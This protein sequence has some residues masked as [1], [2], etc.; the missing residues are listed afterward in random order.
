MGIGQIVRGLLGRHEHRISELYRSVFVDLDAYV[1]QIAR[2]APDPGSILEVGCGEGAVTERI[3]RRYP[4]ADILAIDITP[5]VG[6]LFR[7]PAERVTFAEI[8]VQEIAAQRAGGFDMAIISDVIHHV[9]LD[10]RTEILDATRRA[11]APGGVVVFKDW[12][13][14][15]SPIHWMV[16]GTDRWITGDRVQYL[17]KAQADAMMTRVF[18]ARAVEAEAR[19]RPWRNNFAMLARV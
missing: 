13:R 16:H 18:G 12:E 4:T 2:W 1:D 6:R 17:R 3:A 19:V 8:T 15:A 5:R 7:G 10:L 14:T 11:V 9:P